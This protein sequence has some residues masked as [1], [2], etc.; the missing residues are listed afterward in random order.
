MTSI[1][2]LIVGG[3]PAGSTLGYLLQKNGH[4]CCI[5]EK[6]AFPREKLCGGLLT[7]KTVSL[8]ENIYGE[9]NFPCE[10]ITSNINLFLGTHKITDVTAD[11]KFYLVER[12]D[13][14]YYLIKKYQEI[15][16]LLYENSKVTSIDLINNIAVINDEEKV[17]YKI[18]VGADGANSQI[19][20]YI[21]GDF[22]ANVACLE[23]NYPSENIIE[24]V[25]IYL[26]F[27][28]YG[29][30]WRFAKK[31]H[32]TVG[33]G[34]MVKKNKKL[35]EIFA[36]FLKS[37]NIEIKENE[38]K[39]AMVPCG[40]YVKT[41]CKDNILLIGDA[42]GFVDS[43][44]GEGI[45][46]ALL[47]AQYAHSAINDFLKHGLSLPKNYLNR[48]VY[49]QNKIKDANFFHRF[50]FNDHLKPFLVKLVKGRK[51]MIKYVC[52]NIISHYNVSY[53]IFPFHYLR[54]RN[55]INPSRTP[56]SD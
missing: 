30:A 12:Y 51:T 10:G 28:R 27:V 40:K 6:Y 25:S 31:N 11:S 39:G 48:V 22:R 9:I 21:D 45:Y 13:F 16:G 32:Y 42:A 41:P 52:D 35:K 18:L 23:C 49:I 47:S 19:R 26:S 7:Q 17:A 55:K 46:F 56:L 15:S 53:S 34:G 8:I 24:G 4:S 38:I 5:V 44:T 33:I 20:K 43:I 36:S 2:V 1:D 14:D 37:V 3:G 29:Y 50:Y 54:V